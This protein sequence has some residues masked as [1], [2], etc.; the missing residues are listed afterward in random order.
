MNPRMQ[1]LEP[2]PQVRLVG[3]PRQSVDARR[4]ALLQV[5]E[6]LFERRD[7]DVAPERGEPLLLAFPCRFPYAIQ[8][9]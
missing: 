1:I 4:R 9:V 2:A 5:E 8:T 3:L 6:R 7:V